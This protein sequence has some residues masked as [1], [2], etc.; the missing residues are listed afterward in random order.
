MDEPHATIEAM[1]ADYVDEIRARQGEGPYFIGSLCIGAFVAIEMARI[2]PASGEMVLP[3]LLLDPPIRPFAMP[4]SRVTEEAMVER[5]HKR[6]AMG[7]IEAR[8]DEPHYA[9][10]SVRTA[11]AFETA[12]RAYRA[13][14]YDGHV[15][16]LSSRDRLAGLPTSQL[17]G[18]FSGAID[19]FDV[20][21][22]HTEILDA[23]NAMF[24]AAIKRCL[25][26]VHD[27]AKVC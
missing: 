10:A 22:R 4:A 13:A 20:A 5:I 25:G 1:A 8:I 7:R 26:I 6:H 15:C 9:R 16:I 14:P 2:L 21:T 18:L 23:H 19:R 12:I 27:S 3:L 11:I 24:A 17:A